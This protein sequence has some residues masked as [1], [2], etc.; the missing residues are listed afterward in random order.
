M[1]MSPKRL[2]INVTAPPEVTVF[3]GQLFETGSSPNRKVS[4]GVR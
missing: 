4:G 3:T 1:L 2:K